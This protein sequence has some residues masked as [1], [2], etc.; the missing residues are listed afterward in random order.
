MT[1]TH[2]A[3]VEEGK[4]ALAIRRVAPKCSTT[5]IEKCQ[6]AGISEANVTQVVS[7]VEAYGKP[8]GSIARYMK[9]GLSLGRIEECFELQ[10]V[11]EQSITV[12]MANEF[13]SQLGFQGVAN[14]A[15]VIDALLEVTGNDRLAPNR[16]V[17]IIEERFAGDIHGAYHMA[18]EDP[19]G[20][21]D[22]LSGRVRWS[23][24]DYEGGWDDRT[25]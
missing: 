9:D 17:H 25:F 22:V 1:D 20:Y 19:D 18:V 10:R 3:V 24:N 4:V 5:F 7:M 13:L 6:S 16:L 23:S 15:E 14:P 12:P 11:L 2:L 8:I 21:R